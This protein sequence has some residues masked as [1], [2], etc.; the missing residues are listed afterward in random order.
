MPR[1]AKTAAAS[2]PSTNGATS[3]TPVSNDAASDV[4]L[5]EPY[6]VRVT[7]RGIVPILFHRW[8]VEAIAEK[9][10]APKGSE[11][12]KTDNVE[13]YVYRDEDGNICLPGE[14]LRQSVAE[15]ARNIQD[16]RSSRASGKTLYKTCVVPLTELAP[17]LYEGKPIGQWDFLDTR[18]V[19]VQRQGISRTRPGVAKDW[20]ATV[21]LQVLTPEYINFNQLHDRL[22]AAGRYVGVGD[23]RPTF[24]RF[25]V[26][27]MERITYD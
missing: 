7:I 22:V 17:I 9:A 10:A 21:E 11:M 6:Q 25:S 16:P 8:S 27:N 23:F 19:M 20:Q 15:S 26:V 1:T 3:F 24:G 5:S 13:S 4:I 12:K 18:R 2:P 14:Y